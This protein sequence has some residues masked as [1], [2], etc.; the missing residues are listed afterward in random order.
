MTAG[1]YF[2]VMVDERFA[3]TTPEYMTTSLSGGVVALAG[4]VG[5]IVAGRRTQ[6]TAAVTEQVGRICMPHW[7][8][9]SAWRR[10]WPRMGDVLR[11]V[12]P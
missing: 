8:F 9:P 3:A 6:S 11:T 7:G 5:L 12:A 1:P 4:I 10:V 2:L